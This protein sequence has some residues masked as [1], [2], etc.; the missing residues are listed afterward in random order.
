MDLAVNPQAN[1]GAL[2]VNVPRHVIDSKNAPG[3]DAPFIVKVDGNRISGE[4][5]GI[6]V[7]LVLTSLITLKKLTIQILTEY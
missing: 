3:Q 1:G 4:P 2:E 7:E 5:S 6:C